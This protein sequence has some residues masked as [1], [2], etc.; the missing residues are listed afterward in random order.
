MHVRTGSYT[1]VYATG[2]RDSEETFNSVITVEKVIVNVI[3]N[4]VHN[5]GIET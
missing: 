4:R 1:P 5:Q 2:A 3:P